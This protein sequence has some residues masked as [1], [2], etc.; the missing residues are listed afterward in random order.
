MARSPMALPAKSTK[1][2]TLFINLY[3]GGMEL[4]EQRG[5]PSAKPQ[6]PNHVTWYFRVSL[7]RE[8]GKSPLMSYQS[9]V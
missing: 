6:S 8:R 3:E 9:S 7:Q 1:G 5:G 2:G 4:T